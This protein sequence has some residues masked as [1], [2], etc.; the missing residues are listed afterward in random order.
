M[1][2]LAITT[3]NN[4]NKYNQSFNGIYKLPVN[5]KDS[6]HFEKYVAPLYESVKE[7]P[8]MG[9]FDRFLGLLT[10][11]TGKEDVA[12]GNKIKPRQFGVIT[13][14]IDGEKLVYK[15]TTSFTRQSQ[16]V[17]FQGDLRNSGYK[18]EYLKNFQNLILNLFK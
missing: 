14:V 2:V 18:C 12:L 3:A 16:G 5:S 1:Q 17:L 11:F 9:V 10:V 6:A 8:I 7:Q 13:Q 4:T 15:Y